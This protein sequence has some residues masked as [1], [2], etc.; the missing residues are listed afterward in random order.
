GLVALDYYLDTDT[1]EIT[2][3]P[4]EGAVGSAAC[5]RGNTSRGV[6]TANA[7]AAAVNSSCTLASG[8]WS[9]EATRWTCRMPGDAVGTVRARWNG[10]P[11]TL[12][13]KSESGTPQTDEQI[14]DAL[15]PSLSNPV[16]KD[17]L[18]NQLSGLPDSNVFEIPQ[19]SNTSTPDTDPFQH[20]VN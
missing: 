14:S 11:D 17:I 1:Q 4:I 10:A 20:G 9:P 19:P 5:Y 6:L 15:T 13:F 12:H 3:S 8:I 2:S 16:L 7:C 18:T